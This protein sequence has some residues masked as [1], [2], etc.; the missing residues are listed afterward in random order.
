MSIIESQIAQRIDMFNS[1]IEKLKHNSEHKIDQ[2]N[3][4]INLNS[5]KEYNLFSLDII[6]EARCENLILM[7]FYADY[8]KRNIFSIRFLYG[9]LVREI[10]LGEIR[11][12]FFDSYYKPIFYI[13]NKLIEIDTGRIIYKTNN[14]LKHW[15]IDMQLIESLGIPRVSKI[16]KL[17]RSLSNSLEN[18][19]LQ[20]AKVYLICSL[21]KEKMLLHAFLLLR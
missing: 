16:M 5:T 9:K 20:L 8:Y 14:S 10:H 18:S 21:I 4:T 12:Y 19:M 1:D 6:K 2:G 17:L 7:P 13:K 11:V 15:F 3:Y